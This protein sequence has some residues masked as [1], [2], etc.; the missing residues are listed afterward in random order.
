MTVCAEWV[1]NKQ[2]KKITFRWVE[3]PRKAVTH[4]LNKCY[5]KEFGLR[6][7]KAHCIKKERKKNSTRHLIMKHWIGIFSNIA[8]KYC[9]NMECNI[10][11]CMLL[12][13]CCW[14]FSTRI[15]L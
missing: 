6:N 2:T 13:L 14:T 3:W 12:T 11:V 15:S 5:I 1:K 7:R 9:I 8:S 10:Y 4:I